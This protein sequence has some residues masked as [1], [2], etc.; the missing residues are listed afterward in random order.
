[1]ERPE[2]ARTLAEIA[3]MLELAG[4]NKFKVRAYEKG[5]E[6]L[7]GFPGNLEEAV[8]SGDLR[9]VPGIGDTIFANV[10]ELVTTGRLGLYVELRASFPRGLSDCLRIPRLGAAKVRAL[11]DA[12]GVD[13]LDALERACREGRLADVRGFG[14]K[15]ADHIL[16]GIAVV[17]ASIGL[18]LHS[19]AGA[20][21]RALVAFLSETGLA[22]RVS[23]AGSVRRLREV[24]RNVD[25]V[26]SSSFPEKLGEAFLAFPEVVDVVASGETLSTVRFLD[27]LTADLRIVAP[28]AFASALVCFTGTGAHTSAL[29]SRARLRRYRFET[30]GLFDAQGRRVPADSEADI[31]AAL[32]LA[33]V[34][35]EL[36]E[37]DGEIEAA[38][39]GQLPALVSR[40]HLRGLFHVHTDASDGRDDLETMV[41]ATRDAGY[42]YV[43]ITDHSQSAG[44]AG[45]LTM[46][47]SRAQAQQIR[48]LRA[49][50]PDIRIFHGT[51]ADI[52]A[53][54][55]I[56]YG[57]EFLGELDFVVA[58]VHSRFGLTR[59]EQ[60]ARLIRAVRNPRVAVLGHPT[61]RL[62]LSREGVSADM[63]AVIAAAAESGC[64]LEVNASPHRMDLDWRLV[65]KCVERGVPLAIDPDA[66]S[67]REL[68][69]VPYGLA[70][71]RKGWAGPGAVLNA[72]DPADLVGWLER[73][74]GGSIPESRDRRDAPG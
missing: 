64:A 23:A 4:A 60:T 51:E 59:E 24:V 9:S 26:A 68:G 25:L 66:H 14:K 22:D 55:T 49:R 34:E 53:D 3:E 73:R 27:G 35:P 56:D 42:A 5:A 11:Y 29:R 8:R 50:L 15:S 70:M 38:A 16:R 46:D 67:T 17:R 39:R 44:Y 13:S 41:R 45:G 2:V 58:S 61:G 52:L 10:R 65:R 57:D 20:R 71:A 48:E 18:H 63:D 43:A 74:R 19:A 40:E 6:A 31:Y 72:L 1:M 54:G 32:G 12:L 47:R 36:R 33:Y 28:D 7:L 30:Q 21:A 62:L 37:G 69:Y